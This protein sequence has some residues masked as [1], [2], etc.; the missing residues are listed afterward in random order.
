VKTKFSDYFTCAGQAIIIPPLQTIQM[1]MSLVCQE[2]GIP[3]IN[4]ADIKNPDE[5]S[6][7]IEE[8]EPKI[9]LCSI[10]DI[11]E[12][13][14][15]KNLQKLDVGYLA[16]DESQVMDPV[17]GWCEIRPYCMQTW[18]FVRA[19]FKCPL[20]LLSATMEES[21]LQRV[22]GKIFEI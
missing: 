3:Y 5:I 8:L 15:Q 17:S 18:K 20:L 11:S 22:L 21:S 2:W 12:E 14:I 16:V 19:T 13:S 9:I 7:K 1:Q 4:L 6:Q 10:E